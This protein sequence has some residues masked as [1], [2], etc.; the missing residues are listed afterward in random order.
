MAQLA[1]ALQALARLETGEAQAEIVLATKRLNAAL[2][3]L[4]SVRDSTVHA[5]DRA[6]SRNRKGEKFGPAPLINNVIHAPG[7]GALVLDQLNGRNFGCT[8]DDG[9]YAEIEVSDATVEAVRASV[10]RAFDAL[11]W[12]SHQRRQVPSG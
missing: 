2:P 7:G 4:A 9:T 12:K 11:P 5:E 1:K 3:K 10:Q 8:L 6:R